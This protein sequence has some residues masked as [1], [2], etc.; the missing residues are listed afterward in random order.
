HIHR[1]FQSLGHDVLHSVFHFEGK[2]WRTMPELVFRPERLTRRYIDG[3]R[4]KFISPM[5]LFLFTVFVMYGV[6]A[7]MPELDWEDPPPLPG[8]P[9]IPRFEI[10]GLEDAEP[11]VPGTASR[12]ARA[13]AEEPT[14][15]DRP[16]AEPT[17]PFG[18][19]VQK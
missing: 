18:R 7:F 14:A 6:F 12:A 13:S 9:A 10:S 3:E 19:A 15:D 16:D 5:A 1:T 4:A 11:S 8:A 17:N 2:F